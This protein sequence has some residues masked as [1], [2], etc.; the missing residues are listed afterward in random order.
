MKQRHYRFIL[1]CVFCICSYI[2]SAQITVTATA[3]TAGPTTYTTL[4]T[5]FDA[6]NAG[7]HK[8]V[9]TISVTGNTTETA[10][11][12]LNAS[13]GASSYTAVNLTTTGAFT[14][15]S[16][17]AGSTIILNG[18]D[19]VTM[20]GNNTLTVVNASSSGS[21][22][23][24]TN[25]AVNN[26]VRN[27]IIRGNTQLFTGTAASAVI[28]GGVINFTTG[29]T[30]GNDNNTIEN[31]D[32]DG[33]NSAICLLYSN[34]TSSTTNNLGF[35]SNNLLKTNKFHDYLNGS[36]GNAIA[37]YL[38][39]N[40]TEWNIQDNSIYF[41]APVAT[42][43][44]FL[45]RGMLIAPS[46]TN[47]FH[48]VTG[49]FVGGNSAGATGSMSI[50]GSSSN[51]LGFIGLDIETGGTGNMVSNNTVKNI[52]ISYAA[53]AGSYTN[54]GIFGFIG[55]YNGTTT[56]TGNTVSNFTYTNTNGF[57]QFN[58]IHMNGRV[59]RSVAANPATVTPVFTVTNNT[60][61][62]IVLNSG[63]TTGD[64]ALMGIRLETSSVQDLT[65]GTDKSNP[66][67]IV[68]GNTI[69]NLSSPFTGVLA[70]YIRGIATTTAQGV[71]S[72]TGVTST[73]QLHPRINIYNNTIHSFSNASS[74]GNV[75]PATSTNA[76][77]GTPVVV[78]ISFSGSSGSAVNNTDTAFITN[79][80][81]YNLAATNTGDNGV[82]ATGILA[83]TGILHLIQ[84]KI[85]DL[86][87]S[88]SGA[89]YLPAP[90]IVGIN[91]RRT[92]GN[93]NSHL[94]NN[95][96]SVGSGVTSNVQVFG[97]LNNFAGSTG[98]ISVFYNSV[99]I[100]GAGAAGNNKITAAYQ[101]GTETQGTGVTTPT[102]LFNN[103]FYNNRTGGGS[104]Y[105]VSNTHSTPV[106]SFSS[107]YNNLYSN[108]AATIALWGS[109]NN[110]LAAYKTNANDAGSVSVP[111]SFVNTAT[112]DLHLSGSSVTDPALKAAVILA[113]SPNYDYDNDP[114]SATN[115]TMGAD[116]GQ[117]CTLPAITSQPAAQVVCAGSP[118]SFFISATGTGLTYQWRKDG[119]NISGATSSSFS[120]A[121]VSASDAANYSVVIT[122]ACGTVTS[123]SVSLTVN[124]KPAATITG[125]SFCNT[126]TTTLTV[127]GQGGGNFSATPA[128]LDITPSTGQINLATSATGS[129][130]VKYVFSNGICSD[131][132]TSTVTVSNATLIS[133]QP[134]AQTVCAGST[135]TLSVTATGASL[136]YQWR[137]GSVNIA[138]ANSS[139]YT[140][141]NAT[142]ADVDLYDV[143]ISSSCG[144]PV[145][146]N[147]VNLSLY[148]PASI[149]TQPS[150]QTICA[151][152]TASFT[153]AAA[154]SNLTYQWRKN[155][156]PITGATGANY[157]ITGA[158]I[159][160]GGN[161]DVVITGPCNSVTSGS[162]SLTVNPVTV[163]TTQPANVTG[164]AGT[165][166]TF[167][168]VAG[169][170]GTLSY[171]WRKNST[172]ITGATSS[173]Y[174]IPAT[175]A[176][177]AGNY[178]VQ[179]TGG[180]GTAISTSA[181]LVVNALPVITTAPAPVTVCALNAATF[182]VTATGTGTLTYQWKK[183]GVNISGATGSSFT[184]PSA[185]LTDGAQYSVV[186]SNGSC[187]VT[188]TPVQ[189]TVNAC[190]AVSALNPDVSGAV[191]IP[192]VTKSQTKIRLTVSR[193]TYSDWIIFDAKGIILMKFSR[194]LNSGVNEISLPV[195]KLASG[196][197][198][199][200]GNTSR[201][202][203]TGLRFIK[204]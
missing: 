127:S 157:T 68:S 187:S 118:A 177:D 148:T 6:I 115:P 99:V 82:V 199:I 100:T 49:N 73:A 152:G 88:S 169:G 74:V 25:D 167:T 84:N 44:Q 18:A 40:N 189:L 58:A 200:T 158:A 168:V 42:A 24:F 85:Y 43:M 170:S 182:T 131:S 191:M 181:S 130:V 128:G 151:G 30:T 57:V 102:A 178:D 32:I 29:V 104:H 132:T 117:Q 51:A 54:S 45:F 179:V 3:A 92:D 184:I 11:A 159:T 78:G 164:C 38:K 47:D 180:C 48:T 71:N 110:T 15:N 41:S 203:I 142:A 93:P 87:N 89:S 114:R 145:T 123:N 20:N 95:M 146:S 10:S 75:N 174:T 27:M 113:T 136:T 5:A 50:T 97:I 64:I 125:G 23:T 39:A 138:G 111:V 21:A 150:A 81:I 7:T 156:T 28:T 4:K 153:V 173:S 137:K 9:V 161:Y 204:Q 107:D 143:V 59:S 61:N 90:G 126:G 141:S 147:G 139:S 16:N 36:I 135:A 202:K 52:S 67:F 188:S 72:G 140:I 192:S 133:T 1:A 129:Y 198:Y 122:N 186:V 106:T 194:Q 86:R 175:S 8:G 69:S 94:W 76:N 108:N 98:L 190:T 185:S 55:G 163:I 80:T 60:V 83:T 14:I 66:Y 160:A 101:R 96:V 172:A 12:S 134:N 165:A 77:Y 154:G 171:Q 65:A 34:G 22:I 155:G 26:T 121:T 91:I 149:N 193:S 31:C 17:F 196:T 62:S 120:I 103:I 105:A 63:G 119:T 79:N 35:N 197:Y 46:F 176:T 19:F 162:V 183:A 56:F 109:S 70:S 144:S 112:G 116:E 195:E 53:S 2:G 37:L 201:G 33:Q 124:A 13:G 166:A